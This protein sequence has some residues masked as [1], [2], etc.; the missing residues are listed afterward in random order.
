MAQDYIQNGQFQVDSDGDGAPDQWKP[1]SPREPLRPAFGWEKGSLWVSG[2]GNP[3]I[4]GYWAQS[5]PLEGD[6]AYTLRVEFEILG[7]DDPNL[8]VMNLALW[9]RAGRRMEGCPGDIVTSF[10]SKGNLIVGENTFPRVHDVIAVEIQLGLRFSTHGQVRWRSVQL[11]PGRRPA[12]RPVRVAAVRWGQ[13][14][15][16]TLEKNI[17]Y[18]SDIV[19]Q[20]ASL[21][22]DLVLIPEA[23]DIGCSSVKPEEVAAP[24]P[25]GP[26]C[27]ALAESA[28]TH[29][30][31]VCAG[32]IERD[33]DL[34]FNTAVLFDRQGGFVGSYRKVHPYW[35]EEMFY[36][37]SPGSDFPVF[38][39]DF[40]KVGVVICYDS[41]FPESFRVLALKG[42]EMILMPN[43]GY[44]PL[45]MPA[46]AIDNRVDVVVSSGGGVAMIV[47]S[48]GRIVAQNASQG[49][50]CATLD[51][52]DRRLPHP[53]SGGTLMCAPGGRR[54]VRNSLS[55]RLYEDIAKEVATWDE[56]PETF[57]NLPGDLW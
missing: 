10:H 20:A 28:K 34:L 40:G 14:T 5:V 29:G 24:V 47:D 31:N 30:I 8:N 37:V 56:R 13:G 16:T 26:V 23:M 32:V 3:Y 4:F 39:L 54:A 36:G 25:E 9:Q 41:W 22:S 45:L 49:L 17:E 1:V 55:N 38:D 53:N 57:V 43:A 27:T 12:S 46:R 15:G 2:N 52:S 44:E 51:L 42:A 18:A 21:G 50:V 33:G 6:D 48:L 19:G 7:I 35:P 11:L